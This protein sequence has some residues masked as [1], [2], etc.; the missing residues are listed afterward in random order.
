MRNSSGERF[1]AKASGR[2]KEVSK[3][4][5]ELNMKIEQTTF[6]LEEDNVAA[7]PRDETPDNPVI[8]RGVTFQTRKDGEVRGGCTGLTGNNSLG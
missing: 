1:A 8:L 2:K 6:V 7:Y 4:S 5:E 3:K